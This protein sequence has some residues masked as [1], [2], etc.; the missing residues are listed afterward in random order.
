[1]IVVLASTIDSVVALRGALALAL[2]T[3]ATDTTVAVAIAAAATAAVRDLRISTSRS[4]R[5]IVERG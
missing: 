3:P 2:A 1:V 4:A 5:A